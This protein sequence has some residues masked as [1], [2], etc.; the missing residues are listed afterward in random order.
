MSGHPRFAVAH[1]N[2]ADLAPHAVCAY[3]RA[4]FNYFAIGQPC[5]DAVGRLLKRFNSGVDPKSDIGLGL[6]GINKDLMQVGPIN[7]TVRRAITCA[8]VVAE[9]HFN[10]L[11]ASPDIIHAELRWKKCHLA[12]CLGQ[13][14]IVK[15]AKNIRSQLYAGV[16]FAKRWCLLQY[17][18]MVAVLRQYHRGCEPA[19]TTT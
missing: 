19:N 12:Y 13:S 1:H 3:Q 14:K 8:G 18:D 17:V 15:H 4:A 5:L 16:D 7:H 6:A 11:F 10:D 9:W 2:L